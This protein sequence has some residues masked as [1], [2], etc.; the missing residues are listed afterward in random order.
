MTG[1]SPQ[2][3]PTRVRVAQ[4]TTTSTN[5]N[6]RTTTASTRVR[7]RV[8]QTITN[9]HV[10]IEQ[11]L[12]FQ[13]RSHHSP[14]S[15]TQSQGD[16]TMYTDD[17]A[18]NNAYATANQHA[19]QSSAAQLQSIDSADE[20]MT[21]RARKSQSTDDDNASV[22]STA[23]A[24]SPMSDDL[25][26]ALVNLR[27]HAMW[28][29]RFTQEKNKSKIGNIWDK[30]VFDLRK[31]HDEAKKYTAAQFQKRWNNLVQ[32]YKRYDDATKVTGASG[33]TFTKLQQWKYY[34]QFQ[35]L[36]DHGCNVPEG[37]MM[38]SFAA[39][40]TPAATDE[41]ETEQTDVQPETHVDSSR[42]KRQKT[43]DQKRTAYLDSLKRSEARGEEIV[44][45]LRELTTAFGAYV[46]GVHSLPH[47]LAAPR[48]ANNSMSHSDHDY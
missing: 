7:S 10:L 8:D 35:E 48:V 39:P 45:I 11:P 5:T 24:S 37:Q 14:Q 19:S 47:S 28:I 22:S 17:D 1:N 21:P 27:T 12:H 16:Q 2:S 9:D 44:S 42:Q 26:A 18:G 33:T 36:K 40:A 13:S 3:T 20:N 38:R 29:E 6:T 4:T 15:F 30:L 31:E 43:I 25:V 46:R 32:D 23:T 34:N 41:K